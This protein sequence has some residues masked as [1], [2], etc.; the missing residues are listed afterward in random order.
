MVTKVKPVWLPS[1]P[2]SGVIWGVSVQN[3]MY[4][5]DFAQFN[6]SYVF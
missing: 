2:N 4:D 5:K 1:G 3:F 6:V